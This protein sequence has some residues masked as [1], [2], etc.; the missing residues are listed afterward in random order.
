[1]ATEG[2]AVDM[3]TE[4]GA[5]AYRNPVGMRSVCG[6]RV[7]RGVCAER[8]LRARMDVRVGRWVA[9]Q[10]AVR[11]CTECSDCRF[12]PRVASGMGREYGARAGGL[13]RDD[14]GVA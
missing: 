9:R 5:E 7:A 14:E 4:G 2:G 10:R 13:P 12:R 6:G 1:M 11:A 3:G 8:G